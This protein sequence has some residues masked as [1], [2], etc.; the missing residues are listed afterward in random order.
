MEF[1]QNLLYAVVIA[2]VPVVTTF[3]CRLLVSLY[4]KNQNK[5]KDEKVASVIKKVT[6][7]VVDAVETTTSTYVKGLKA[8][9][10]FDEEAHKE[11]FKMTYDAVTKQLTEDTTALIKEEFGDIETYLTN[12]IESLVEQLKK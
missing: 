10:F 7:I 12:K 5:I 2:A 9:N 11:A 3:V 8:D 6:N 1:L 4:D